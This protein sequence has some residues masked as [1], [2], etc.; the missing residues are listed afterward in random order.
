LK[1]VATSSTYGAPQHGL[2]RP[3]KNDGQATT[4][5]D[6]SSPFD[7]AIGAVSSSGDGRV[8][9]LLAA[10]IVVTTTMVWASARRNPR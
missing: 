5:S 3:P 1:D 10:M 6:E 9:W 7:A 2:S 4:P 8:Y